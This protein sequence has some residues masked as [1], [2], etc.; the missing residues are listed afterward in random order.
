MEC[1]VSG[2]EPQKHG[3]SGVQ[4]RHRSHVFRGRTTCK[5]GYWSARAAR[6]AGW[7]AVSFARHF[8]CVPQKTPPAEGEELFPLAHAGRTAR[9][10]HCDSDVGHDTISVTR[11]ASRL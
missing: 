6:D 8:D 9:S 1:V 2:W 10:E 4:L 7:T 5:L 3:S 11:S